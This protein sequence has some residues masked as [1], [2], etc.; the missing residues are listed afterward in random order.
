ME[1]IVYNRIIIPSDPEYL[2]GDDNNNKNPELMSCV[3]REVAWA[4][5][6]YPILPPSLI[7]L[8]QFLWT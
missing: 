2:A 8:T 1:C 4:L 5:I 6:P 7:S 3:N